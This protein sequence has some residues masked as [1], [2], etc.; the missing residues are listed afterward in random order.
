MPDADYYRRQS[1]LLFSMGR[2]VT[3]R[4]IGMRLL[5]MATDYKIIADNLTEVPSSDCPTIAGTDLLNFE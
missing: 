5:A 3:D 4:V 2:A 1:A